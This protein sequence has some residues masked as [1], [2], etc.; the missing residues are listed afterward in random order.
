MTKES[1][2]PS[3]FIVL[4]EDEN[5]KLH[6]EIKGHEDKEKEN[7]MFAEFKRYANKLKLEE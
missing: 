4:Y 1:A 7:K 3:C 5:G 6:W 2:F